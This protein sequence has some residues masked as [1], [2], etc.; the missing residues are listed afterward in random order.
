MTVMVGTSGD[1]VS[2]DKIVF[3]IEDT[4]TTYFTLEAQDFFTRFF[5]RDSLPIFEPTQQSAV[6]ITVSNAG[7]E[8]PL[9]GGERVVIRHGRRFMSFTR[10]RIRDDGE[11]IDE[12]ADDNI[13]S[14]VWHTRTKPTL[15]NRPS[16]IFIEVKDI[17]SML[18]DTAGI[19]TQFVGL[20]YRL[21]ERRRMMVP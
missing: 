2:I 13:Y 3:T 18:I 17:A 21:G 7:P 12:I 5:S 19:H 16:Q 8:D 4:A 15:A 9:L 11:G 1:K 14:G 20:P 10:Q 6:F